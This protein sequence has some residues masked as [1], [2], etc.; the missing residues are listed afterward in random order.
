MGPGR[1]LGLVHVPWKT[2]HPWG[3]SKG[4]SAAARSFDWAAD[5]ESI[6]DLT[7]AARSFDWAVLTGRFA[8]ATARQMSL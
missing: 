5:E 1:G 2:I 4:S 8:S 6:D 7:G 3:A